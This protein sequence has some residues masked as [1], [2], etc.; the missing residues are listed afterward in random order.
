MKKKTKSLKTRSITSIYL[1][2]KILKWLKK[3]DYKSRSAA[4]R[5][6]ITKEMNA[7]F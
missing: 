4:I 5:S 1:T 2:P 3:S 7:S 6:I